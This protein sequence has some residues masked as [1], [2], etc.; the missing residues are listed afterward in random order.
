MA[1]RESAQ[2]RAATAPKAPGRPE[3]RKNTGKKP[4]N[5]RGTRSPALPKPRY[6]ATF[7][8]RQYQAPG[9]R[10]AF[11]HGLSDEGHS[12]AFR[13]VEVARP[14]PPRGGT[15]QHHSYPG[16]CAVARRQ[17][18]TVAEGDRP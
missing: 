1:D 13:I 15:P 14:R 5:R 11:F 16:Q 3:A 2:R 6:H 7:V 17:I 4:R 18:E 9:F 12:R 8:V 10:S